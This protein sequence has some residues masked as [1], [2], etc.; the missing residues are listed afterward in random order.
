LDKTSLT[1]FG[2]TSAPNIDPSFGTIFKASLNEVM[3][4]SPS[5]K[6]WAA[7]SVGSGPV[8]PATAG[9][10]AKHAIRVEIKRDFMAFS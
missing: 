5:L 9:D 4:N 10:T 7:G 6:V 1:A 2:P 8:P 3:L